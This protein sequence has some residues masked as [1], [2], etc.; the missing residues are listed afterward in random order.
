MNNTRKLKKNNC[1]ILQETLAFFAVLLYIIN[2]IVDISTINNMASHD[3]NMKKGG[4]KNG[5]TSSTNSWIFT[6]FI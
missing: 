6:R 3:K 2:K 5:R 4:N 1:D